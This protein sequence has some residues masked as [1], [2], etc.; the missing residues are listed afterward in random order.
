MRGGERIGVHGKLLHQVII[1]HMPIPL[2][3]AQVHQRQISRHGKGPRPKV[4]YLRRTTPQRN[5]DFL[6]HLRSIFPARE[7]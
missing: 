2:A 7:Q 3:L 1:E 6:H 5:H 4:R